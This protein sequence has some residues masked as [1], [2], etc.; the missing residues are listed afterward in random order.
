MGLIFVRLARI[1]AGLRG[2]R[3]ERCQRAQEHAPPL[4]LK[5]SNSE[6]NS[7][8]ADPKLAARLAELGRE[9]APV[10]RQLFEICHLRDRKE[11]Q[12]VQ[13]GKHQARIGPTSRASLPPALLLDQ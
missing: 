1:P 5:S 9:R 6:I 2:K 7:A 3:L 12:V 4:S 13:G 11:G 10:P 8:L